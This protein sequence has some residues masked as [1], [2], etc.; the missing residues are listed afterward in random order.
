MH[1]RLQ[2][3]IIIRND[4]RPGDLGYIIYL[5]GMLYAQEYGFDTTFE[6]YVAIPL[7][8]FS[9]SPD[10]DRQ[11]IWI[12]ELN[13]RIVGCVAIVR[14]SETEA[15]L[16]WLI[17]HPEFRGYKLGRRLMKEAIEFSKAIGYKSIFLWTVSILESATKVYKSFGFVKI[18]EKTHQ[19]WG[20]S[21]TEEKYE[22]K[23]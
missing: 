4:L 2:P 17:V 21:L 10:R 14:H 18:E 7:S 5:H 19:I 16:R 11:H 6:P 23:L 3:Q 22:L 20:R 15:Q 1:D 9:L 13:S 12:A 8:E